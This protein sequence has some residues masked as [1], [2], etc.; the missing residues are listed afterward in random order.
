VARQ[1]VQSL[2][3]ALDLLEALS[4]AD[5]LGVSELASRTGLVP[6]TAHRLLAT[7]VARGYAAQN[8]AT[9][10]YLTGFKLL[11]LTSGLQDRLGRLRAAARP[12]LEAIQRETGETTNLVVLEGRNA[13]Y[14]DTVGGSRSVRLF[15][16]VGQAIPAHTS[17]SGKALLA[18]R[19]PED[20]AALFDGEPLAASTPRTLTA[21]PALEQDLE[22]IRRQ[23]YATDDEEHELGV[24]C[25]ATPV[26]DA[27]GQALAAISVTGPAPRI[28]PT[29]LAGLLREHAQQ[30]SAAL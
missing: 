5:E 17:G 9:G 8:P 1:R 29:R 15:I 10:R 23:G 4:E 20:L 6:S 13:V 28:D 30:V 25:V 22:R 27:A 18:W 3:R 11:E 14:V 2:D 7:L 21:L 19:S 16:E 24:A 26:L 12:H